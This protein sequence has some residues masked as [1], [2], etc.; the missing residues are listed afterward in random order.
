[1]NSCIYR[2]SVSHSRRGAHA[3]AFRYSMYMLCIDLAELDQVFNNYWL[4]STNGPAIARF[5]RRDHYGDPGEPLDEC[6]RNLVMQKSGRRP[7]G[8]VRLLTH[9]RYFGYCF[10]PLSIYYCYDRRERL[11]AVVLEVSNTPWGQTHCYV[12][13]A[14]NRTT[15][16]RHRYRFAKDFHVS[17]FMP[18][19]MH[20]DCRLTEPAQALYL[21]L[22]NYR[23]GQRVFRSHLS[24][25]RENI[26]HATL[27]RALA[28]DPLVTLRVVTLIHWQAL[29]LWLKRARY[30]AYPEPE[31]AS[32]N[33]ALRHEKG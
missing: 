19:D 23:N 4:W 5:D 6:I 26:T 31:P 17:P 27:A 10:N 25:E 22:D 33:E 13:S 24:M 20:Y 15:E 11:E 30:H 2:G 14:R 3:N 7:D 18:M 21:G 1:M 29:R 28:F 8:P 32:G 16:D 9:L 12:L